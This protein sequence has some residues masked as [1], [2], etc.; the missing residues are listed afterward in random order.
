[1][2]LRSPRDAMAHG[3][4]LVAQHFHLARRHTVAENLALALPG[5][6]ALLPTRHVRTRARAIAERY[7][8][9]IDPDARV[10]TL[11]P[12]EQQRVEILKALLQGARILILDEPTSVLTPQEAEKLFAV[13]GRMTSEGKGIVFIS[14]KLDEVLRIAD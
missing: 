1:V 10:A 13:V 3:V 12:G 8:F 7:G 4:G 9:D 11:S 14:H 6:P 5:V 2:R